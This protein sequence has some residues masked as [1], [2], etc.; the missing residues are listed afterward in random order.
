MWTDGVVGLRLAESLELYWDREDRLHP[1]LPRPG[2]GRPVLRI[3]AELEKGHSDRLLPIAPEFAVFLLETQ[4][5]RRTGRVFDLPRQRERD[6][7]IRAEW[8][9]KKISDIGEK[10]GV[11]VRTDP[12]DPSKVNYASAHDLRR[13]FGDRWSQ[14]IMPAD[15]QQLMRHE[16]IETTLRFY[17]GANA[18]RTADSCWQKIPGADAEYA[19][20]FGDG[21]LNTSHNTPA[22]QP[23]S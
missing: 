22:I 5:G 1:I 15:L 3:L 17:V 10:A 4:E 20:A 18:E 6:G 9:G 14:R 23:V 2:K 16:S 8:V 13:S 19:T 7:D 21:K 11:K 12:S